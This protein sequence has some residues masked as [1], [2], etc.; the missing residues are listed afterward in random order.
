MSKC[1][2]SVTTREIW[3]G[4]KYVPGMDRTTWNDA[5]LDELARKIDGD[6]RDLRHLVL[7]LWGST[8]IGFMVVIATILLGNH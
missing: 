1:K 3:S 8:L 4:G 6:F 7:C 2:F 5:R